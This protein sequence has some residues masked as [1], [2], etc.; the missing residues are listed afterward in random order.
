MLERCVQNARADAGM[1]SALRFEQP[2]KAYAPIALTRSGSAAAAREKHWWK[3][4]LP[5]DST[6]WP[7]VT[8]CRLLQR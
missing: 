3:A 7:I 6:P 2:W 4:Y 5:M 1:V 8:V